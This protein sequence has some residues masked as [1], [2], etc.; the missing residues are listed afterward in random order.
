MG[1]HFKNINQLKGGTKDCEFYQTY[2]MYHP[3]LKVFS[4]RSTDTPEIRADHPINLR[5]PRLLVQK[6][7]LPQMRF[8]MNDPTLFDLTI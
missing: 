5:E 3:T 4:L 1:A 8:V 7:K 6:D 2:Q